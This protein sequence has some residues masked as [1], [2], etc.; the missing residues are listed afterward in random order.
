V[1]HALSRS[2]VLKWYKA[3]S[4]GR[5]SIK[6]EPRSG[7]P[8]TS[9]TDNNVEIV[10][11]LVWSDR[12]LTVRMIASELNLNHTTVHHILTWELAMKNSVQSLFPK[13]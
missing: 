9:K 5:E 10:L 13:T 4:E 6:G 3:F 7:K 12:R 2:Q 1:E 11:A 8:S